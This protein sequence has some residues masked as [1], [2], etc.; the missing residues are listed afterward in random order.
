MRA[1]VHA[2]MCAI[3]RNELFF[4]MKG[5][6]SAWRL[7][8]ETFAALR[9]PVNE[10]R[11]DVYLAYNW[12]SISSILRRKQLAAGLDHAVLWLQG[13]DVKPIQ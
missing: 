9:Q 5:K 12:A 7:G 2:S 8:T 3:A 4:T 10:G 11:K 1:L 6:I 13:E